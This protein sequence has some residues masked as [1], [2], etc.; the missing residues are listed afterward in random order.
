MYQTKR[1]SIIVFIAVLAFNLVI[2]GNAAAI[3][4]TVN[5]N[6]GLAADFTS[7]QA[8]VN[9]ANPGDEIIVKPGIYEENIE[10][11]KSLTILSE[12]SNSSDTIIQAADSSKDVFGIWANEVSIKGFSIRGSD[13]AAGIHL[14]GVAD[15]HIEHNILSNNSCGIDFYM[16][17]SGNTLIDNDVSDSLT[18]ISLGDSQNNI[19]R[20]NSVSYCSSGIS[21]FD[22]P[23]NTLENNTVSENDGGISL[24]G[25]SNGNVLV[26]NTI[27]SN[28]KVGLQIYETS[29][30]LI[31]NNYFNNAV[32]V[33]SELAAGE[34]L[35][36]TTRSE[37]TN[38]VGGSH[39]GGNFWGR[40]DGT[41]YPM[42]VRD[43]DLD[44]IFDSMYDIE[45]SGF[46]DYL[47]LKESKSTVI[48]VSNSAD[49][50]ADF[51]SI[52]AAV[53][54]AYP[55]D[56]ILVYP[57]IY[58]ENVE[59]NVKDLVVVSASGSPSDTRVQAVRSS[60]DVF[61]VTA[62][63]VVIS[64]FNVTGNIS[65][66]NSGIHLYGV[67]ECRIENNE[68]F[69]Y[70]G[71]LQNAVGNYIQGNNFN[72]NP[73]FGIR[74]DFS[75]NNTLSNNIVSYSNACILLRSS[76]EN[77][78]FNN[79]VSNSSYGI[80]VDSSLGNVL[81]NNTA[82]NNNI[83]IY[84]KASSR[85]TVSGITAFDNPGSCINLLD[86]SENTLSNNTASNSSNVCII[87]HNSSGNI[88]GNNKV[89]NSNYGIWLDSSSNGN[90]LNENRASYTNKV[91]I[92][93]K[94]SNENVLDN[95]MAL[96]NKKYGISLWDSTANEL[97][98]NTAS[99]SEVSILLHNA[100][101][102]VLA[103]NTA[104]D[105]SYGFWL[106]SFSNDN[107]LSDSRAPNNR[108]GIYLKGSSKNVLTGNSANLNSKYGVYLNSSGN[109]TFNSNIVDSNS[110]YGI[111]ILDSNNN[112]IYNNYFNNTKNLYSEGKSSGNVWNVSKNSGTNIVG[113]S[114][115][116]GN[117]WASP[118][119][120]GFSQSN[121]DADGDGICE[122][123]YDM[124][125]GNID[126]LPLAGSF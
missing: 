68:L 119:G 96:N 77:I 51:T 23:G 81:E 17:S 47:P 13:S 69:N 118:E 45:G 100:S 10:I 123:A 44:G 111:C 33:E 99:Y 78:L 102:N 53:Y 11:T 109:N 80:W 67:E 83:G 6:T 34:N 91:G 61:S 20:N 5:D 62:D 108:I 16:F 31:Y 115:L 12:S 27:K 125:K 41:V 54:S 32:N 30:N 18:G 24:T 106:D 28:T 55:G 21:L 110:G 74:L 58:V 48:T 124:G 64:G 82:A 89:F 103:S 93:L 85:N 71:I 42:G 60:E 98:N 122:T 36:N 57:G 3:A 1:K 86:S 92:Y 72:L 9:A 107:T 117:F 46:I 65:S 2:T 116:G 101:K 14:Y 112:I 39:L 79:R 88:L 26:S 66:P 52:Q 70:Q 63:G 90:T 76:N 29:S 35:W 94:A 84:L 38:I 87:L 49:H 97:E 7:I 120:N 50:A 114:F 126:Y 95:N 43:T 73:G 15:C 25:V 40:P 37:G 56:T 4:I 22:S 75:G 104:S 121:P 105:S 59:I 113:K 19:L 8:A